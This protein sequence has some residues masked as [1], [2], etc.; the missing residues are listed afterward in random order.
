MSKTDTIPAKDTASKT[1]E[2]SQDY[3]IGGEAV[4][5][6]TLR[7]A[8]GGEL[9]GLKMTEI[10]QM[11]YTSMAKLISRISTPYIS[12]EQFDGLELCDVQALSTAALGFFA[13]PK[14]KAELGID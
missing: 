5:K 12:E 1:V 4:A 3:L 11:D 7:K 14:Q 13:H 8:K 2:L 9:R 10:F 6:I